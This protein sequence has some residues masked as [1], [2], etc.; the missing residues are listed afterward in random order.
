[1]NTTTPAPCHQL[2]V[3]ILKIIKPSVQISRVQWLNSWINTATGLSFPCTISLGFLMWTV[4]SVSLSWSSH[5]HND[6][7]SGTFICW[8]WGD[9]W[10]ELAF[11]MQIQQRMEFE[12][13]G[14][15]WTS[16]S[17]NTLNMKVEERRE[18]LE[19]ARYPAWRAVSDVTSVHPC[20]VPFWWRA[21]SVTTKYLLMQTKKP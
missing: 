21:G 14:C 6:S 15:C 10:K 11:K 20:Q 9:W 3:L 2:A 1:M 12:R 5:I 7:Q 18:S 19:T 16:S 13:R 8:G 17:V 4:L